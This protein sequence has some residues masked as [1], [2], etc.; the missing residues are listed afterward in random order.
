MPSGIAETVL[1]EALIVEIGFSVIRK[2]ALES[3]YIL[4]FP[5]VSI[6]YDNFAPSGIVPTKVFANSIV[7][8]HLL[9]VIII[10]AV[11]PLTPDIPRR[12]VKVSPA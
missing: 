7:E 12:A 11:Y 6:L 4:T 3:M 1:I 8:F 2:Y 5:L 10:V 9:T